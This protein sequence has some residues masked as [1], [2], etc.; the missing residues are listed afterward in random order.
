MIAKLVQVSGRVQG[1]AYRANTQEQA[2]KLALSGWVKNLNNGDVQV[3]VHGPFESVEELIAWL[4]KCALVTSVAAE[5]CDQ[6]PLVQ[7]FQ[8]RF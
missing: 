7:G 1:V 6:D 4:H 3:Y 5:V 8:I 2:Q